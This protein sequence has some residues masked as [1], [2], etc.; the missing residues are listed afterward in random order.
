[1]K[2]LGDVGADDRFEFSRREDASLGQLVAL[3]AAIL[4][5]RAGD[6]LAENVY[7][8]RRNTDGTT[9]VFGSNARTGSKWTQHFDPNRNLQSG[10]GKDGRPWG[11]ARLAPPAAPAPSR[12]LTPSIGQ[13]HAKDRAIGSAS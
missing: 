13:S 1:M 12:P 6:R 8:T 4:E 5:F 3:V 11:P 10:T 9:D 7:R 2:R